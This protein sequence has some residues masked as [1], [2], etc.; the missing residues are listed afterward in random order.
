MALGFMF[1]WGTG[2]LGEKPTVTAVEN[3]MRV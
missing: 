2:D 3:G 1:D